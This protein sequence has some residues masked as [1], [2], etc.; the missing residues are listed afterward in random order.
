MDSFGDIYSF[1]PRQ[2]LSSFIQQYFCFG[3]NFF[4]F[5]E[6]FL[7]HLMFSYPEE[8]KYDHL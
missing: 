3:E 7:F 5:N 6:M 4:K 2:Y 8:N 1:I